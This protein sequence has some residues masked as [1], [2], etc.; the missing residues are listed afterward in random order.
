MS[1]LC[2]YQSLYVSL[3]L[4]KLIC[5]KFLKYFFNDISRRNRTVLE[6]ALDTGT[7]LMCVPKNVFQRNKKMPNP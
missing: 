3:N 5:R 7:A 6:Y 2:Q 4:I 1:S